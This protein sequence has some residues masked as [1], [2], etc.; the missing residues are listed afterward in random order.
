MKPIKRTII[1]CWVMLVI[2]FIIKLFGGNWFEII[3]TNEHFIQV[4]DFIEHNRFVYL[5]CSVLIYTI[6]TV[7]AILAMSLIPHPNKVQI[8]IT[9]FSLIIVCLSQIISMNL[10]S[11]LEFVVFVTLPIML[12]FLKNTKKSIKIAIKKYWYCGF[13]GYLIIFAFQILSLITKNI[14]IKITSDSVLT[15]FILLIDYYIMLCLYYLYIKLY[16]GEK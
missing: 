15:T 14:G 13:V 3:C 1:L 12:N 2:C 8:T 4:C 6:P 7:F 5:L 10:K 11:I 9:S 16:K